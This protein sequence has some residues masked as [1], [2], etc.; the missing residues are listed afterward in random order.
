MQTILVVEDDHAVQKALRH[1]FENEG[2]R[3]EVCGDGLSALNIFRSAPPTAVILT[4]ACQYSLERTFV[5]KSGE[6]RVLFLS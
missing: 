5:A 6:Q 2:Y 3:V 1:L 4:W